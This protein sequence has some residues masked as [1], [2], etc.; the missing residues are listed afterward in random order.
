MNTPRHLTSA[1]RKLIT[2][3]LRELLHRDPATGVYNWID[4][5]WSN[6]L[7]TKQLNKTY[8]ISPPFTTYNVQS[9][10]QQV[11][12]HQFKKRKKSALPKLPDIPFNTEK[13]APSV[14]QLPLPLVPGVKSAQIVESPLPRNN[15]FKSLV[16]RIGDLE[17]RVTELEDTFTQP[18]KEPQRAPAF[19]DLDEQFPIGC[20]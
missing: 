1:E 17:R 20:A 13:R 7:L 3:T 11:F 14:S 10:R 6:E 15:F 2:D 4:M 8:N 5:S 18:K 12:G 9:I 16:A 19:D